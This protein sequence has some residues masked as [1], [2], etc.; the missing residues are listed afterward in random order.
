MTKSKHKK[1]KYNIENLLEKIEDNNSYNNTNT[2]T[3]KKL[4]EK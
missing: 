4:I 1:T 3:K 2:T